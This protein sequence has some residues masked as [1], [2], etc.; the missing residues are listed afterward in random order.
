MENHYFNRYINYKCA[1]FNNYAPPGMVK[2]LYINNGINHLST[3]AGFLPSTVGFDGL[4][5]CQSTTHTGTT[6]PGFNAL[7]SLKVAAV[8]VSQDI[9]DGLRKIMSVFIFSRRASIYFPDRYH[10]YVCMTW[11]TQNMDHIWIRVEVITVNGVVIY[12]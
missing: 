4:G 10:L 11:M 6:I 5:S 2:T 3:G 1:I 12:V 9:E 8:F 7:T